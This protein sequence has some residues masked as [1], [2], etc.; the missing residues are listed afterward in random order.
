[1]LS[2]TRILAHHALQIVAAVGYSWIPPAEDWSHTSSTWS[3]RHAALVSQSLRD[4]RRVA[5]QIETLTL[6]LLDVNME[7]IETMPLEQHTLDEGYDWLVETLRKHDTIDDLPLVRPDHDLPTHAVYNGAPFVIDDADGL[8]ELASWYSH[9]WRQLEGWRSSTP[10]ASEVRCWPHHFDIASLAILDRQLPS[11]QQ[12]SIGVGLSP[13]DDATPNP[14]WYVNV[15]PY[16][17]T[18]DLPPLAVGS[19]KTEGWVGALLDAN[20]INAIDDSTK[21]ESVVAEFIT[22][23]TR[24]ARSLLQRNPVI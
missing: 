13:G 19:W 1:M 16:P 20:E 2:T 8:R 3:E 22:T 10:D 18:D 9:A 12:R 17:P 7:V 24:I 11:E 5:V 14:Y 23:T 4:G 21:R 6:L 15:W